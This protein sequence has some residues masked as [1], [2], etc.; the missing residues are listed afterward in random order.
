MIFVLVKAKASGTY[1][2]IAL[3]LG[4]CSGL[5][6]QRI[7][8]RQQLVLLPSFI[9]RFPVIISAS[10]LLLTVSIYTALFLEPASAG[11]LKLVLFF[12]S[13]GL[14]S[15]FYIHIT[16]WL[17]LLFPITILISLFGYDEPANYLI[18]KPVAFIY[19]N[20]FTYILALM[21]ILATWGYGA[22]FR[23]SY[24]SERRKLH[25]AS[26]DIGSKSWSMKSNSVKLALPSQDTKTR[27]IIL[28]GAIFLQELVFL[29]AFEG[30]ATIN[31]HLVF[32]GYS[33]F[34]TYN[35]SVDSSN[36]DR[37]WLASS[38]KSKSIFITSL[39][40]KRLAINLTALLV[41]YFYTNLRDMDISIAIPWFATLYLLFAGASFTNIRKRFA[42]PICTFL[43][44]SLFYL[45]IKTPVW[46]I[47][48]A[49]ALYTIGLYCYAKG[50][51]FN[52]G[53]LSAP[54]F[55]VAKV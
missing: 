28:F 29:Q 17:F 39:S 19:S 35:L 25:S 54:T 34:L 12:Y 14:F 44:I 2:L 7:K 41:L 6:S 5:L 48:I 50:Y 38:S 16:A 26:K 53:R 21:F 4:F 3:S 37:L 15:G 43:S 46:A 51:G 31:Q 30:T 45:F 27:F 20:T 36:I 33:V 9:K 24:V 32:A 47:T 8:E 22:F 49:G 10:F 1:P 52:N 40:I 11:L 13:L 42:I 23:Q 55:G 18:V